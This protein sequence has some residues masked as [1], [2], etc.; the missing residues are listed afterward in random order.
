M[1]RR[2][3]GE[4]YDA[5]PGGTVESGEEPVAAAV[6]EIQEET[7]LAVRLRGP[8][9]VLRNQ[10]RKEFYFDATTATGEAALG[11][12]EVARD[13]AENSYTLEWVPLDALASRPILPDALRRWL[14]QRVWPEA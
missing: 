4:I 6:R 1:H 7:G 3:D 14:A 12:P 11:G 2:R 10:G 13:S 5:I 9:L 8:V